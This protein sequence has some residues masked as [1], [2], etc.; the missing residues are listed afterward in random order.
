MSE[1]NIKKRTN[2]KVPA[3]ELTAAE[4]IQEIDEQVDVLLGERRGLLT[5]LD[6]EIKNLQNLRAKVTPRAS[7]QS[8]SS[9]S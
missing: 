1:I 2:K 8:N 5:K 3:R 6:E 4:R 9:L 7:V